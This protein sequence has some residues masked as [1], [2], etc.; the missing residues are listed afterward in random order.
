MA[1][2][3]A[4]FPLSF[5]ALTWQLSTNMKNKADAPSKIFHIQIKAYEELIKGNLFYIRYPKNASQNAVK[6]VIL[7]IS[8]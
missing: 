6:D 7:H 4:R 8:S 2:S 1:G 3:D 5:V